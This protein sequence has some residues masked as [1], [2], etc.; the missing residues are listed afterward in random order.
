MKKGVNTGY[1]NCKN[2][3]SNIKQSKTVKESQ[4]FVLHLGSIKMEEEVSKEHP[5]QTQY[6][7]EQRRP[8]HVTNADMPIMD[9]Q[10]IDLAKAWADWSLKIKHKAEELEKKSD[11]QTVLGFNLKAQATM[12]SNFPSFLDTSPGTGSSSN[13]PRLA[14]SPIAQQQQQQQQISNNGNGN[15]AGMNGMPMAA[16][17][18]ADVNFL[19]QKLVELSEVLKDNREKTAGVIASAEELAVCR[20]TRTFKALSDL[21]VVPTP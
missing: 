12:A 14:P 5:S 8:E 2:L 7:E 16:G 13:G 20:S 15:G 17:Q 10:M 1:P 11:L 18:Q 6:H 21:I 9:Q 4:V 19:F 3:L